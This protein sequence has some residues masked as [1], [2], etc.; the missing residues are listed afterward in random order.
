M[1]PAGIP[2]PREPMPDWLVP[3]RD[4]FFALLVSLGLKAATFRRY[5]P[6]VDR[7]CAEVGRQGLLT[8]N[9]V[10]ETTLVAIREQVLTRL[11]DHRRRRWT[12][13]LNRFM[14]HL[15]H[16]GVIAAAPEPAPTALNALCADYGVWLRTRCGSAPGTVKMRQRALR[17]FLTF[18]FGTADPGDLKAITRADI[19]AF[20]GTPDGRRSLVGARS[21]AASLRSFF[22]FLL[23]TGRIDRNLALS[24]PR[25]AG[26]RSPAP[27]RHLCA[28]EVE[29]V[30]AAARGGTAV[31]R[32][33][34]AMLLTMARLGLRG[35]EVIAIRLDDI[36]WQ[37][38]EILI[39]GKG[40][41]QATMPLPVDVGRAMVNW[42]RHGRRGSSRHLFVCVRP[43]FQPFTSPAPVR[44]ALRR[45]HAASGVAPPGGEVRCHVFRH[46]MAMNLLQGG[47]SLAD[48]G[49]VLRHQSAQT[50]TVYARHD[51]QALRS[52][53]RPWP[54]ETGP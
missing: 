51:I 16:E 25:I 52:L 27:V 13:A 1:H 19:D 7:L 38:G 9:D 30:L 40:G 22:R 17:S 32:R 2:S 15:V 11:S 39:R 31:A 48:I 24:V 8:P 26:P 5:V 49:N 44:A 3:L 47:T 53:A 14:A 33:G 28:D 36:D 42:I 35:E 34:H 23:A 50:T 41:R 18:R 21:R 4:T 29:R 37:A 43:P 6:A 12:S 46:S 10:D 20:L 54:V 45:A